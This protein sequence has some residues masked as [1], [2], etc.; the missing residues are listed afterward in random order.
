M[1]KQIADIYLQTNEKGTRFYILNPEAL[2]LEDTE[3]DKVFSYV[4][5]THVKLK[6]KD[7]IEPNTTNN[8]FLTS[9]D[10]STLDAIRQKRKENGK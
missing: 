1:A 2:Q 10:Q 5:P 3:K 4:K 9:I 8:V 7:T 6:D